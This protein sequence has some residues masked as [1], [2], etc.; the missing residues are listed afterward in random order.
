MRRALYTFSSFSG[1]SDF[2]SQKSCICVTLVS[3]NPPVLLPRKSVCCHTLPHRRVRRQPLSRVSR[4]QRYNTL[5][6]AK[7]NRV[8]TGMLAPLLETLR[9]RD[10]PFEIPY[11]PR[12][13]I[14]K[15][16]KC[17]L[18]CLL[19]KCKR[20]PVQ[21]RGTDFLLDG[22]AEERDGS[23]F[24]I[25]AIRCGGDEGK[26]TGGK[27]NISV[28]TSLRTMH[29]MKVKN[30]LTAIRKNWS[31][32]AAWECFCAEGIYHKLDGRKSQK[33]VVQ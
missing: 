5:D 32:D 7:Q 10:A 27:L 21:V 4:K 30:F 22:N 6:F 16:Q 33:C 15:L 23:F 18:Q 11:F 17:S 8:P 19:R 31:A 3:Q 14:Y 1:Q 20:K 12:R 9:Q 24:C 28:T 25:P 2:A 26:R 29:P 13:C